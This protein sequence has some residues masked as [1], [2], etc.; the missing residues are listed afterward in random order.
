MSYGDIKKALIAHMEEH[1]GE[2]LRGLTDIVLA[3]YMILLDMDSEIREIKE[4]NQN[5][6]LESEKGDERVS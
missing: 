6:L 4:V 3:V 2:E 1:K 5:E